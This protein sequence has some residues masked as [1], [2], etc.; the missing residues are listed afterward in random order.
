MYIVIVGGG[1]L[2]FYLAQLLLDEHH[3]C[4]V[5]DKDAERCE[6]I[7]NHLNIVATKGDA[8]NPSVLEE[9]AVTEA[10][11]LIVLT[12]NDET[13]LVVSWL[14]KEL[15]AKK[16]ATRLGKLHYDE[17]VLN[18]LGID[19]V[20]HPEAAAAGY[21]EELITK[22]EVLDLAFISRGSAEIME[23]E[24]DKKSKL[25]GRNIKDIESPQGSAI[26]AL[27][28]NKKLIIPDST[29]KIKEGDKILVLATTDVANSVRKLLTK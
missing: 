24:I 25:I 5:I 7:A 3:D 12:S 10:D 17:A 11:A 28:G 8:T 18:R 26:V 2:G 21:I 22:P 23:I 14:A 6:F 27:F 1:K 15:G 19:L 20:I 4:L 9:A 29:T 16:V 13:N